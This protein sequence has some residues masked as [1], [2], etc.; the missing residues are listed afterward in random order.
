MT[1]I[2]FPKLDRIHL[3]L[4][5]EIFEWFL[6]SESKNLRFGNSS[7]RTIRGFYIKID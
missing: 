2:S 6:A 4:T 7:L 5:V 1:E 3:I